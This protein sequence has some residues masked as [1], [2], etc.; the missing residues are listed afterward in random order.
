MNGRRSKILREAARQV[1]QHEGTKWSEGFNTFEVLKNRKEWMPYEGPTGLPLKDPDT[2][3][4]MMVLKKARGT[5]KS[6]WKLRIMY[7]LLKRAWKEA[8]RG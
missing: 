2:G 6:A 5:I 7:H 8:G 4:P 1:L 3:E